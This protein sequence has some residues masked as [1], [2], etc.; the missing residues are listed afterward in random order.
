[1]YPPIRTGTSFY[2]QNLAKSLKEAGHTIKVITVQNIDA[3]KLI[4]EPD[5]LRIPALKIPLPGF[6]KH[7]RVTSLFP[8]NYSLINNAAKNMGADVILLVNHYLDIAFPAIYAAKKRKIPLFCSIGTQ[9]QS[10]NPYRNKILRILDQI[11]CGYL[12]FP[13]CKKIIAWDKQIKQYLTDTHGDSI[14]RKTE[15]VNYGVNGNPD[16]YLKNQHDYQQ[17]LQILGVGAI[18]EQRSFV[19]LVKAFALIAN[20]FPSLH[21]K[22]IGHIY[23]DEAV[24]IAEKLNLSKRITFAGELNHN[25]VLVEMLNSDVF[26]SSLTGRYVGLGTATIES[27]LVG[28]PT[29]VNCPLD[30]LGNEK[31]VDMDNI[32]HCPGLVPEII[33]V[34]LREVLTNPNLRKK[35]GQSGKE[36]V[37]KN[38][39]WMKVSK[40]MTNLFEAETSPINI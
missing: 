29:I 21:L 8:R 19:P 25:D 4:D 39:S 36:F 15:I 11:I 24:K 37:I 13:S 30:I 20:E 26:Y 23:Y 3:D 34:K 7:F 33:A 28:L 17:K 12:I 14:L 16:F 5:V 10:L 35:I 32:I 9:L 31:L 6:F 18:S 40:D 27:M 2:T 1:M 38:M 22:I